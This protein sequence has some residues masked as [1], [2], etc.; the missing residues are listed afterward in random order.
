MIKSRNISVDKVL[1]DSGVLRIFPSVDPKSATV[2]AKTANATLAA[3]NF[4]TIITNTGDTDNI[5]LT[6]P[7][8]ATVIE[9]AIRIATTAATTITVTPASGE[10]IYLNG[11]GVA[12]KYLLIAGVIGNFAELYCDG[13][14]YIV[15]NY[16]GVVTK[17]A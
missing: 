10:K 13:T 7:A 3:S 9:K 6:L 15:T 5:V 16:N 1:K 14:D 8:A 4:E 12:S 17:E 2:T 11:S